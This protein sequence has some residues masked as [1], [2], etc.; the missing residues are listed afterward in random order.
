MK[1]SLH[2]LRTLRAF[3]LR[4]LREMYWA[5]NENIEENLHNGDIETD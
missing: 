3:A 2:S 1:I 4:S 5:S